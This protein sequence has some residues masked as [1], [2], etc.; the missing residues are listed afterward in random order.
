M[1]MIQ[2]TYC[3]RFDNSCYRNICNMALVLFS[4]TVICIIQLFS[5]SAFYVPK[6]FR[7]GKLVVLLVK[8]LN[9]TFTY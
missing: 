7:I 8:L 2:T 5:T 4:L 1:K 9:Q 6:L 3:K